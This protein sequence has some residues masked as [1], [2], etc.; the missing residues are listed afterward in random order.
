MNSTTSHPNNK[1]AAKSSWFKKLAWMA[2]IWLGSIAVLS[3]VA[4]CFRYLMGLIN[5]TS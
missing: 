1:Q 3:V 4:Y 5:F 2:L